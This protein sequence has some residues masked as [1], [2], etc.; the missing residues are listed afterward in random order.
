MDIHRYVERLE[1][2]IVWRGRHLARWLRGEVSLRMGELYTYFED[3]LKEEAVRIFLEEARAEA[4]RSPYEWV[5]PMRMALWL[6]WES[7]TIEDLESIWRAWSERVGIEGRSLAQV[8]RE[9][10][11]AGDPEVARRLA[12]GLDAR[13]TLRL[14]WLARWQ[15]VLRAWQVTDGRQFYTRWQGWDLTVWETQR[16]VWL[17]AQEA[18]YFE[19]YETHVPAESG[20]LPHWSA[21]FRWPASAEAAAQRLVPVGSALIDFLWKHVLQ[22]P[23][24]GYVEV[25]WWESSEPTPIVGA[26]AFFDGS[27]LWLLRSAGSSLWDVWERLFLWGRAQ[28]ALWTPEEYT[29]TRLAGGD[30]SVPLGWGLWWAR[31]MSRPSFWQ[32]LQW[33]P[34][35][36]EFQTDLTWLDTWLGRWW[37]NLALAPVET[38][39]IPVD[40]VGRYLYELRQDVQR[41]LGLQV[42]AELLLPWAVNRGWSLWWFRGWWMAEAI[43]R[44]LED[45]WGPTWWKE[46]AARMWLFDLWGVGTD[47]AVEDI[48][49]D[50]GFSLPGV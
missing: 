29:W 4:V 46:R 49:K 36:D 11:Q 44:F 19:L 35:W 3:I 10:L 7:A 5:A 6:H 41:S 26:H 16:R 27:T 1:D 47:L 50:L 22:A 45:R 9:L 43:H 23:E 13:N 2:L 38:M 31:W 14:Q 34:Q 8:W 30:P 40:E 33:E 25:Q 18:R 12:Q 42:E 32:A 15:A 24:E 48:L 17:D 21:L 20:R 37:A 28:P 39:G